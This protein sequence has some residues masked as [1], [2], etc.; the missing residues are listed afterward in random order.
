MTGSV[1]MSL[2]ASKT[3]TDFRSKVNDQVAELDE[4]EMKAIEDLNDLKRHSLTG[5]CE[6]LYNQIC[7]GY[8]AGLTAEQFVEKMLSERLGTV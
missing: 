7:R 4:S 6:W 8:L 5:D 2:N 1:Y 3:F